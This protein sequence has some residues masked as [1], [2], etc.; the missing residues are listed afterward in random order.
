MNFRR[1][2][3]E[4][5]SQP[6]MPNQVPIHGRHRRC[7]LCRRRRRRR[8]RRRRHRHRCNLAS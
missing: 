8:C 1:I 6:L 5:L 3:P 7:H 4:F 2:K